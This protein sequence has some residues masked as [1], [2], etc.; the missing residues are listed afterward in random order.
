[1][2]PPS[3][4]VPEESTSADASTSQQFYS[5]QQSL[6]RT[7]SHHSFSASTSTNTT[8][9]S[10]RTSSK[11]KFVDLIEEALKQRETDLKGFQK[12]LKTLEAQRDE[13]K[14]ELVR[15]AAEVESALRQ[16]NTTDADIA[17]Q[18]SDLSN[19]RALF[20]SIN[21][22]IEGGDPQACRALVDC[23]HQKEAPV[24]Q[25]LNTRNELVIGG[26]DVS[27]VDAGSLGEARDNIETTSPGLPVGRCVPCLFQNWHTAIQAEFTNRERYISGLEARRVQAQ[28]TQQEQVKQSLRFKEELEAQ[29][30]DMDQL[31]EEIKEAEKDVVGVRNMRK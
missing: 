3:H 20:T 6:R 8:V 28:R 13:L 30:K 16:I 27:L 19:M 9:D 11:R 29:E 22:P 10:N 12:R 18:R 23:E 24:P 4:V 17:S 25:P 2:A 31:R 21:A 7:S 26:T 5:S 1:M 14:Y 15:N